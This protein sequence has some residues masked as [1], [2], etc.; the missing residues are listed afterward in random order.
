MTIYIL[1]DLLG[2]EGI[3][4]KGESIDATLNANNEYVSGCILRHVWMEYVGDLAAVYID[5]SVP[6][7]DHINVTNYRGHG[8]RVV[9]TPSSIRLNDITISNCATS[10]VYL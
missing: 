6:F 2:L 3:D 1:F 4:F 5:S 9:N 8:L 10:S 7:I